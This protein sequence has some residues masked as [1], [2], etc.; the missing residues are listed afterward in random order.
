MLVT[1]WGMARITAAWLACSAA[2]ALLLAGT[3]RLAADDELPSLEA[4]AEKLQSATVTVRV[5][6]AAEAEAADP[7]DATDRPDDAAAPASRVS[8]FTGVSL[9]DGLVVTALT[10]AQDARI[11]ITLAGGE[12]AQAKAVVL[13]E[14]SGLALL[15]LDRSDVPA[16][17]RASDAPKVGS[18]VISAAAWG[19]EKPVVM[20]GLVSGVDR[21]LPGG[22]FPPLLQCDM[23][24]A[25]TSSG[26]GV[27][28]RQG[29]LLGIVVAADSPEQRR[30]FTYAVP[31]GHVERLLRALA[32][33]ADDGSVILLRHQRPVVGMVLEGDE[34]GI[35]VRR[36]AEGSP[37][38]KAGIH[39]GDKV[40]AADGVKIRSVYQAVRPVL[41]KQPGDVITYVVEQESGERTVDVVL[42]GGVSVD[43]GAEGNFARLFEPRVV[44][45]ARAALAGTRQGDIGE[46]FAPKDEPEAAT[47]D[48]RELLE[49]ALDRYR[50]VIV[51]QQTQ[52]VEAEQN[53]AR[54]ERQ[55]E[56]LEAQV[57]L[58]KRE[59]NEFKAA[60][61]KAK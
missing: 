25:E 38:E 10:A 8:V 13:D 58:L 3:A 32:E 54:T 37:A 28:N 34:S 45:D 27:V 51:Y 42:G 26:A 35:T 59:L 4:A 19:T 5:G 15:K 20:L 17:E 14:F 30:G 11:R 47:S 7:A 2:A 57:E 29:Q 39:V 9:G 22:S 23:R 33:K 50:S 43:P 16:V 56:A 40:I 6:T 36:V 1:D 53:R 12:Q 31:V 48:P 18:W 24:T 46:V 41:Y 49:K 61:A 21:S 55:L 44:V 60:E 52:L